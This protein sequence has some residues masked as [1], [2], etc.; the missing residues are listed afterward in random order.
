MSDLKRSD[1]PDIHDEKAIIAFASS[2]NGYEHFDSFE[3]CAENA[4]RKSRSNLLD[5]RNELFFAFRSSRHRD[6]PHELV[7]AYRELR[8]FF[9][10]ILKA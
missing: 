6:A 9:E 4:K 7:E 2:F 1:L 8:P 3:A 10:D 5:L